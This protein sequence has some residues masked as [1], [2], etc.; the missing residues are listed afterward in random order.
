MNQPSTF[1]NP[2]F[3]F[4]PP[5]TDT[6]LSAER[7]TEYMAMLKSFPTKLEE[8]LGDL[9]P[10]Q[11]ATCYRRWTVT[12]IVHHLAD[13]QMNWFMRFK[14]AL[15]TLRPTII[16]FEQ[17]VWSELADSLAADIKPSLDVIRGIHARWYELCQYMPEE[18]FSRTLYHPE[19]VE[20]QSL[21]Q[22]LSL[23]IWHCHHHL[24]QIKWMRE[25]QW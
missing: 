13:A 4:G 7:R 14:Q 15:T 10:T 8:T 23:S 17:D 5:P 1:S 19:R 2:D 18:D 12:Q 20:E 9:T 24:A 21:D 25:N 22:A 6:K 11:L 3:P 16:P